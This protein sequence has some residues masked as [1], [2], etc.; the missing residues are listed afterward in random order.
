MLSMMLVKGSVDAE[1]NRPARG[2]DELLCSFD[3]ERC[4][5][6]LSDALAEE[7]TVGYVES[8]KRERESHQS[9]TTKKER[10]T[11]RAERKKSHESE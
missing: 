8:K 11:Q 6:S 4:S 3:A 1:G 5:L 2:G 9:T 10:Q 7:G